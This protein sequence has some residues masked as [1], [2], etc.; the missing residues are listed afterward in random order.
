MIL[1]DI[2]KRTWITLILGTFA[3]TT[4]T[5]LIFSFILIVAV[6]FGMTNLMYFCSVWIVGGLI[7]ILIRL[8]VVKTFIYKAEVVGEDSLKVY[9]TI[10]NHEFTIFLNRSNT[11]FRFGNDV[12]TGPFLL[13]EQKKPYKL[14]LTQYC[15]GYW[16]TKESLD[17][18]V[19][20]FKDT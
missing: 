19:N 2:K 11:K 12:K 17:I 9:Y 7:Y 16:E 1:L 8:D 5:I 15:I 10:Y 3:F 18:F 4:I 13:F 14:L 20:Y 6:S